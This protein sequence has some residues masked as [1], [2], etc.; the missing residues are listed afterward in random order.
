V[1]LDVRVQEQ[2]DICH[3]PGAMNIPLSSLSQ[4]FKEVVNVSSSGL[5]VYCICRRGI[6]S[7]MATNM[8][9][10]A[11]HPSMVPIHNVAGGLDAWRAQ[12]DES[13]PQY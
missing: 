5:P 7:V 9:L 12:I 6:A 13:F 8:I 1:L 4:R 3:L 2:F 11:D 10:Q